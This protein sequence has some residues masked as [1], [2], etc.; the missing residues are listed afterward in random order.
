MDDFLPTNLMLLNLGNLGCIKDE[1]SLILIPLLLL[2]F[3]VSPEKQGLVTERKAKRIL[4]AGVLFSILAIW[5]AMYVTFTPVGAS[6]IGG[7]QARYFIPLML[8]VGFLLWNDRIV[9]KI[10]E[11]AYARIV[12]SGV[13]LLMGQCV[14]QLVITNRCV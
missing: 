7:V 4:G 1:W 11:L 8:P 13:L 12:L 9:M 6:S 10:K 5:G 3:L 14:W 2:L